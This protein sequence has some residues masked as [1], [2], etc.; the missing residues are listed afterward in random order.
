MR[1]NLDEHGVQRWFERA[2][3]YVAQI[4]LF[5]FF[6]LLESVGV[7]AAIFRPVAGF[8]VVKK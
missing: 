8:H 7:L 1:A 5:P 6:T 4:V 3:W 2:G